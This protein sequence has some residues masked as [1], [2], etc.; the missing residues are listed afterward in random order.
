M[1]KAE[2][3]FDVSERK[4]QAAHEEALKRSRAYPLIC[5]YLADADEELEHWGRIREE[6]NTLK[7]QILRK[8]MNN[9]NDE[10]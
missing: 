1:S 9:G 3:E 5:E 10:V 4:I 8:L 6:L 7:W 2:H